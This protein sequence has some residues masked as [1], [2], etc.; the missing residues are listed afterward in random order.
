MVSVCAQVNS[1]IDTLNYKTNGDTIFLKNQFVLK[2]SIKINGIE[3]KSL[4]NTLNDISGELVLLDSL[5]NQQ[6]IISY[7][8]LVDGLP[9]EVGPYWKKLPIL[10]FKTKKENIIKNNNDDIN[11]D[12]IHNTFS[13]GSV[14]RKIQLSPLSGSD[15]TGGLQMQINGKLNEDISISGILTD[16]DLPFQPEG[17]TREL[18]DLDNVYL[19]IFHDNFSINA[20]DIIYENQNI[21]RKLVGVNSYFNF[22]NI[23]GSSV[24]AKSKGNFKYLELKGRDGDQGPYQ[25]IGFNG[26]N[27][28][29]ILAGTERVWLDGEKLIRGTNYDYTIDYSTAK[30]IFTPKHIIHFDSDLAFE[31]Q[32]SDYQYQKNFIGGSLK[33]NGNNKSR[34]DIGFYNEDDKNQDNDFNDS[35][36]D[37]LESIT[38]ESIL[39]STAVINSDGDYIL[40][41]GI[42]FYDISNDFV[43][44][45]RYDITFQA[46]INGNYEKKISDIGRIFYEYLS[47]DERS[48]LIQLYS[49][50]RILTAPGTHYYGY[51]DYNYKLSKH[52]ELHGNLSGSFIDRNKLYSDDL[53][54]GESFNYGFNIDSLNFGSGVFSSKISID[55]RSKNFKSFG[56][57]NGIMNTRFWNLDSV[58]KGAYKKISI[59]SDYSLEYFGQSNFELAKLEFFGFDRTR[60]NFEQKVTNN[61]F[62]NSF[63]K[64][65]MIIDSIE[66]FQRS[67]INL[68]L[69]IKNFSP[70]F[71]YVE[72]FDL[73][74]GHFKNSGTGFS[75]ID[76]K[77]IFKTGLDFRKDSI[78]NF[79][80]NNSLMTRDYIGYV[81][82]SKRASNGINQ[83][84]LF[85]KR[86]KKGNQSTDDYNYSLIDIDL[87][88]YGKNF[89][90][91]WKI[92]MRQEQTMVH[93]RAIVYDSIGIG[94]GQFRYDPIFNTYFSDPNGSYASYSILTG[95][96]KPSTVI[97]GSQDVYIDVERLI[98]IPNLIIRFNSKQEF[99][100]KV[101]KI[102]SLLRPDISD[103]SISKSNL[104]SRW[105]ANYNSKFRLNFWI[106]NSDLI[107][108]LDPRGN[109]LNQSDIVGFNLY[110]PLFE[111]TS[112]HLSTSFRKYFIESKFTKL[113]DRSSE[114]LWNSIELLNKI[115][116]SIDFDIG[117]LVGLENGIQQEI[118]FNGYAIGI[119]ISN[120]ILFKDVGRF[121]S[122][123]K[124]VNVI[125][126]NDI[127]FLPPE[128]FNGF[129]LG[130]SLRTNSR[131]T[132]SISRSMSLILSLNTIDD[133]R[134]NNFISFQG[135]LRAY[136]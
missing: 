116:N 29:I 97:K 33:N 111:Q 118:K 112:I 72:E 36:F 66:S 80:N 14:Y 1:S 115:N 75:L 78:A 68:Q 54:K 56:R 127:G 44:E 26:E 88:K 85:K 50:F 81:E 3:L 20:G 123:I 89:P 57:D 77:K 86:I 48:D 11:N 9:I 96:K 6:L 53:T 16:Q 70:F 102:K 125:E 76:D 10:N 71:K 30:V 132:Y 105:E 7:D 17:T 64:H 35:Y 124:Y 108:G 38:S 60:L 136:F 69:N 93:E 15:F 63:F 135:E 8:Y 134:Y 21:S 13:S 12:Y 98:K 79:N 43:D 82:Y 121:D 2:S 52:V 23:E 117:I 106:E 99:Q 24:Y 27:D 101:A 58:M 25:L 100:G 90:L 40:N 65:L 28:I 87:S 73:Y 126:K 59:F 18:E 114:G 91:R 4:S 94:L 84:I 39:I 41:N 113:R 130:I 62:N 107:N 47:P 22:Q 61:L 55:Q 5:E 83:N 109:D 92:K 19:K 45:I 133:Y 128:T 46:D 110:Y 131:F 104:Y 42:Y 31:Y 67:D 32:F 34:F 74:K 119:D 95:K 103:S 129:P 122:D 51:L 37:S 49:P 120:K